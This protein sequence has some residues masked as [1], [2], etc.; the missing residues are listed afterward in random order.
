MET[1]QRP[2][3]NEAMNRLWAQFLPQIEER[4]ATLETAAADLIDGTITVAQCEQASSAAH[5]LAGVLGTFGLAEGTTLARE[6][7]AFYCIGPPIESTV[8]AR[9]VEVAIRLR[10]LIATRK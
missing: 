1:T 8:N 7:E 4:V 2:A 9:M 5:N 10:R 3:L 6:A